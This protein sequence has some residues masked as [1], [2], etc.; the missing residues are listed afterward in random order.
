M[1][2]VKLTKI[3]IFTELKPNI[4]ENEWYLIVDLLSVYFHYF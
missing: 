4:W 3:D 1:E 2:L